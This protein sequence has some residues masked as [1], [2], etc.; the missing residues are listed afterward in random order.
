MSNEL[1]KK[2]IEACR[3]NQFEKGIDLFNAALIKEPNNIEGLFNR[4]R[5]LSKVGQLEASLVDFEKLTD[6]QPSNTSFIGDYA[7]SLHLN[8]KN[9]EASIQFDLVLKLEPKNPYGYSSRAYFKDRTGDLEGAIADYEKAIE[10]DP[11]DAISLNNKGLIEEKLGY[12]E[13]SKK[14]FDQSNNLIGYK[15]EETTSTS[16]EPKEVTKKEN[17][18]QTKLDVIKSI[19]TK[20]GFKDFSQF[21]RN[22]ITKNKK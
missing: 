9:K 20:D 4:A 13:R 14:S 10:L 1:I 2:G 22:L 19:F 17:K 8:D 18:P 21:Y 5:A 3:G 15:P 12:A 11:E 6:L 7:V 16:L